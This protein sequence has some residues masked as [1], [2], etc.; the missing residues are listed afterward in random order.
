MRTSELI[1]TALDWAVA[2]CEGTLHDDGTISDYWQPSVDW[3]QG[4]SIIE[5]ERLSITP[6]EGYWE[7]YYHDNLFQEDESDC[8]QIGLTP[9]IAAMRCYVVNKLGNDVPLPKG[10]A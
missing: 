9:L 8:F 6:R 10:L 1:G 7:A 3:E 2:Q 5:R 4:G